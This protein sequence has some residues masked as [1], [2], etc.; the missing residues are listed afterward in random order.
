MFYENGKKT[1]MK[2]YVN[3]EES[4]FL[5]SYEYTWEYKKSKI[6]SSKNT[7]IYSNYTL[8]ITNEYNKRGLIEKEKHFI[9]GKLDKIYLYK[10]EYFL[11]R[12]RHFRL[13]VFN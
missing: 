12:K 4:G 10:Y 5:L 13:G 2:Q 9:N 7:H 1:L 6:V 8:S 11:I 3:F